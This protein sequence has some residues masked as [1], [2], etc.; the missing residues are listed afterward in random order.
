[1]GRPV[2]ILN[3]PNLNLLGTREPDIYGAATLADIEADLRAAHAD[4]HFAQTNH[5]GKLIDAV[6]RAGRE[7]RAL[8]LNPGGLTHTSVALMD[9]VRAIA[10]PTIEVHLSQ[11]AA[12]ESFRH[13]SFVAAACAGTISGFGARSYTL[14]LD[15]ALAMTED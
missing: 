6:Q 15:A 12:R 3:G 4:I 13:T 9:A 5:E 1:M 2:Y 10:I 14:A 11:P 7:A 8:V